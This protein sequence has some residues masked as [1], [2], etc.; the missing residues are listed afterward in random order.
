M[1]VPERI[2]TDLRD[3]ARY[4]E[5]VETWARLLER[6]DPHYAA[7]SVRDNTTGTGAFGGA[8]EANKKIIKA[9]DVLGPSR[10]AVAILEQ[11]IIRIDRAGVYI[12]AVL[13]ASFSGGAAKTYAYGVY[14][15]GGA[16]ILPGLHGHRVIGTGGDVGAAGMLAPVQLAAGDELGVYFWCEDGTQEVVFEDGCFCAIGVPDAA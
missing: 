10:G 4:Q 15:D 12:V 9:F 14:K 1:T 5:S 11:G 8:L 6:A 2:H 13:P 7:I 16:E 3:L